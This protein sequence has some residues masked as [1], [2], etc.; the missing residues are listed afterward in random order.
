MRIGRVLPVRC[1]GAASTLPSRSVF[2]SLGPQ[3]AA[4]SG[5][6]PQTITSVSLLGL[7]A[8]FLILASSTQPASAVYVSVVTQPAGALATWTGDWGPDGGRPCARIE[9]YRR[10]GGSTV[11]F[12]GAPPGEAQDVECKR[13]KHNYNE[14]RKKKNK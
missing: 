14:I 12:D 9:V 1:R 11:F 2:S 3:S 4:Y 6:R 10:I 5:G 13:Q 7:N 8:C